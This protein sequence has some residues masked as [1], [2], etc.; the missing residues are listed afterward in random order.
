MR[1]LER[2]ILVPFGL[3]LAIV[4]GFLFLVIA[5]MSE[6]AMAELVAGL[7]FAGL[8]AFLDGVAGS[9]RPEEAAGV[10]FFGLWTLAMAVVVLPPLIVALVG[11]MA[12]WR[13]FVWYG[14][15]TGLATASLPWL[16]RGTVTGPA[17]AGE[18]RITLVLFL[19]GAVSGL[20]YWAVA[21]RSA[22]SPAASGPATPPA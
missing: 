17:S 20:A 22:G 18:L 7:S 16:M 4:V 3:G 21:G 15:A 8:F 11:E 12:G 14:G 6:P 5:G 1:L 2:L 10:L 13:S 9:S 19:T